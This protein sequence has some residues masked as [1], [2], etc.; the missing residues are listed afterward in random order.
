MANEIYLKEGQRAE[1]KLLITVAEWDGTAYG[2]TTEDRE[3]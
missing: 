1:R 3:I 2:G